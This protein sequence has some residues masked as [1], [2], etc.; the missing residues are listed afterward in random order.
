MHL[1][2]LLAGGDGGWA[3]SSSREH[4][5]GVGR[6]WGPERRLKWV[7][8][9]EHNYDDY[10]MTRQVRADRESWYQQGRKRK[11]LIKESEIKPSAAT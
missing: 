2:R 10:K 4:T 6:E 1:D 11:W 5:G 8:S 3:E 7:D 9:A